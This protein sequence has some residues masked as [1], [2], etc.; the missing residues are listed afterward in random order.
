M[1]KPAEFNPKVNSNFSSHLSSKNSLEMTAPNQAVFGKLSVTPG[2]C[3]EQG[4][5]NPAAALLV[6]GKD[7]CP[8]G[9]S[10]SGCQRGHGLGEL[11]IPGLGQGH[12]PLR[13]DRC[14]VLSTS[15]QGWASE[16]AKYSPWWLPSLHLICLPLKPPLSL[17]PYT[18]PSTAS[19]LSFPGLGEN[20]G[21]NDKTLIPGHSSEKV[22][23]H[24][25]IK[26]NPSF[27]T[28]DTIRALHRH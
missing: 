23:Q 28:L 8:S 15:Q 12:V 11:L 22:L 21:T 19:C 18:V 10:P 17:C 5:N 24:L 13:W 2:G 14:P 26:K 1:A 4:L 6:L 3:T 9:W 20:H 25:A 7:D 16:L 27:F